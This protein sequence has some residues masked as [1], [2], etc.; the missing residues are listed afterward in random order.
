MKNISMKYLFPLLLLLG[1]QISMAQPAQPNFD[2]VVIH[3]LKVR[4]DIY[5]LVGSG[6][7]IT[8]QFGNDGIIVRICA[9]VR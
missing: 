3:A 4:D 7:N 2:D 6:G 5:M 8:V 9:I 1:S